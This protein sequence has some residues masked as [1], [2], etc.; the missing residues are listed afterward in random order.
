M[1]KPFVV[2]LVIGAIAIGLMIM[3]LVGVLGVEEDGREQNPNGAPSLHG[4]ET[5]A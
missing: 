2:M 1:K 3:L 4:V 5:R